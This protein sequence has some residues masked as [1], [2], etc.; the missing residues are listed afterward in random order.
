MHLCADPAYQERLVR[1]VENHDEPRASAAFETGK[2]EAAALTAAC[3]PGARLFHE[4]QFEG[5]RVRLPVF[6]RRRP[7]EPTDQRLQRFYQALVRL[8]RADDLRNGE[9]SL[10]ER[11]GWPDNQSFMNL[12]AWCWRKGDLRHLI[13]VNL[14]PAAAQGDVLLPWNDLAGRSWKLKDVVSG[15]VFDRHGDQ[16]SKSG[17]YVDLNAWKFH[18]LTF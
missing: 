10:C 7:D 4:G 18:V 1:F 12:L 2:V 8:L 9:W 5:R 14:S 16:L 3:L 17:L 13:V 15:D 6:L 11:R